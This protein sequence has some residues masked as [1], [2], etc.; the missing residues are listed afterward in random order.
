MS[1]L[2]TGKGRS[3]LIIP[4]P[5]RNRCLILELKHVAKDTEINGALK[6]ASSQIIEKKY[7]SQL[8]YQGYKQRIQYGMAF[9]DKNVKIAR[10][11]AT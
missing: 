2:E 4:D 9:C 11:Y 10:A 3:D 7:E 8:K 6:E 1:E 5:A